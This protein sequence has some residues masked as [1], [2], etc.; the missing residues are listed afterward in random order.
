[1]LLSAT[2]SESLAW[3]GASKFSALILSS[4]MISIQVVESKSRLEAK[5]LGHGMK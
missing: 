5:V 4:L 3:F 1:V 2:S